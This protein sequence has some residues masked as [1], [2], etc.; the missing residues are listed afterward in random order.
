MAERLQTFE[1]VNDWAK[2]NKL[3]TSPNACWKVNPEINLRTFRTLQLTEEYYLLRR[4][5][6]VVYLNVVT[7]CEMDVQYLQL[8]SAL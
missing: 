2:I 5:T 8:L 7:I 1:K 6:V 3:L 4:P